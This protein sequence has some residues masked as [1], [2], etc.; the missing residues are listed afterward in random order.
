MICSDPCS[1]KIVIACGEALQQSL[2]TGADYVIEYRNIRPDGSTH[3]VDLRARAL[4]DAQGRV[5]CLVG[6][7]RTSPPARARSWSASGC[8]ANSRASAPPCRR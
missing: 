5:N 3:W 7:R 8:S 2:D 4:R 6:C 1:R